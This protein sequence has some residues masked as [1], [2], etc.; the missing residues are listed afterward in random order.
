MRWFK[1]I[2]TANRDEKLAIILDEFGPEGYGIYFLI[3][4]TIGEQMDETDRTHVELPVSSW[5][6]ILRISEK[7]IKNFLLF[8]ENLKLFKISF[9]E[10]RQN[11]IRI[12]CPKM[13]EYRDEHTK[14]QNKKLRSESVATPAQDTELETE[15]ETER[16]STLT[17]AACADDAENEKF[18]SDAVDYLV[19]SKNPNL[20]NLHW[21]GGTVRRVLGKAK[22]QYPN[23]GDLV[24]REC[25]QQTVDAAT[26]SGKSAPK[27]FESAFWG[28]IQDY[29][30]DG[31]RRGQ[32]VSKPAT[33]PRWKQI[34]DHLDEGGQV[35]CITD[36]RVFSKHQV[37]FRAINPRA[38]GESS[39]DLFYLSD[40]SGENWD[41]AGCQP[42]LLEI[43]RG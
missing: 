28:R 26:S 19:A 27:W 31:Q 15:L 39:G 35:R 12:D 42:G 1:H 7:K 17:R 32:T 41:G 22:A 37:E 30:P 36:G 25:W 38:P 29:R 13:V 33:T 20:T 4:E 14:K 23:L 11:L 8:C 6:R 21:A 24:L 5:K 9:T 40:E 43:I 34:L 18:V 10:N 3:L 2:S 16:E